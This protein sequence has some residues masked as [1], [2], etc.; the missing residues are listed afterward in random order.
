MDAKQFELKK[1]NIR[2]AIEALVLELYKMRKLSRLTQ[3]DLSK[4]TGLPQA[5]ISRV[6]S[7]NGEP[8]LDTLVKIADAFGMNLSI[9][10]SPKLD[11]SETL[12]KQEQPG[13]SRRR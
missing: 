6:E 8:T 9:V 2:E 5:T 4:K 3:I 12:G 10:L 13:R 1:D 7:F 11:F